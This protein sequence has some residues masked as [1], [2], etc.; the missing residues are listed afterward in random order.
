MIGAEHDPH[1]VTRILFRDFPTWMMVVFYIAGIAALGSFGWGTWAQIRKYRRGMR[2]GAWSPF[3]PRFIE[4]VQTVLSH[5]RSNAAIQARATPT[6]GSSMA[7]LSCSS[8]PA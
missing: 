3:W 4:M 7:S 8:A 2:S 5:R 1:E 6:A